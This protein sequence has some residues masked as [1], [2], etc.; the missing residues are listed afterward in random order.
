M[1]HEELVSRIQVDPSVCGGKPCVR[2]TR[3]HIATILGGLAEG[4]TP[5]EIIDH[6]PQLTLDDIHAAL[7]YA[8]EQAEHPLAPPAQLTGREKLE[9]MIRERFTP[10]TRA[11]RMARSLA[12]LHQE[13]TIKLS[14]EEWQR[15][16]EDADLKEP[17][18]EREIVV[19]MQ[20]RDAF[21]VEAEVQYLGRAKP[22]VVIDPLPE[23]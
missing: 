16:T 4:L 6:Y 13:P 17:D 1:S 3:I 15:I 9:A 2:D 8:A 14:T 18:I 10:E 11:E 5:E 19:G 21:S 20:P 23:E 7:A 22:R 12:A